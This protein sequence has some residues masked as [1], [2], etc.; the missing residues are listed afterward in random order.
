MQ[1]WEH[2]QDFRNGQRLRV[3]LELGNC[4]NIDRTSELDNAYVYL[5]HSLFCKRPYFY[6]SEFWKWTTTVFL[7]VAEQI[8]GNGQQF[9]LFWALWQNLQNSPTNMWPAVHSLPCEM[10]PKEGEIAVE[11]TS[12]ARTNVNR[13]IRLLCSSLSQINRCWALKVMQQIHCKC[14]CGNIDRMSEMGNG[15]LYFWKSLFL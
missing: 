9:R 4:G 8:F 14:N 3:F 1:L 13:T 6:R 5:W 10:T 2:W 15:D 11:E 12:R 7:C